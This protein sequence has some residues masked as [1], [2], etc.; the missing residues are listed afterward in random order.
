MPIALEIISISTSFLIPLNDAHDG[1]Y[2]DKV[3]NIGAKYAIL[4]QFL[5]AP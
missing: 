1:I 2:V 5:C 3:A 4:I